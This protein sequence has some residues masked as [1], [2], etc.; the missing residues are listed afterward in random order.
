MFAGLTKLNAMGVPPSAALPTLAAAL[1]NM[2]TNLPGQFFY[3]YN[4]FILDCLVFI[5]ESS[6]FLM[7]MT[8]L[9][10]TIKICNAKK[11]VKKRSINIQL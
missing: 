10:E 6:T 11:R 2:P 8:I 9:I 7:D 4:N 5:I 1:P 3:L